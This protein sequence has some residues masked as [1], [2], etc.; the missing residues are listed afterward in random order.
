MDIVFLFPRETYSGTTHFD[1]K[2]PLVKDFRPAGR[3][4]L[5]QAGLKSITQ[6]PV[7]F[8][9]HPFILYV[10]PASFNESPIPANP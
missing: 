5:R 10:R 4:A 9:A 6:I 2:T 3:T 7:N 8:I 1:G